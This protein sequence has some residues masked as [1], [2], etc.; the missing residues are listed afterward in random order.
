M[1]FSSDS[2]HSKKF[3]ADWDEANITHPTALYP[4]VGV[5]NKSLIIHS[6]LFIKILSEYSY[7]NSYYRWSSPN[8]AH[9]PQLILTW[10]LTLP[11]MHVNWCIFYFTVKNHSIILQVM[12]LHSSLQLFP[13][14][15]VISSPSG[16][17]LWTWVESPS[18]EWVG[19]VS[20]LS[21]IV[22]QVPLVLVVLAVLSQLLL[23]L[24]LEQVLLPSH[25]H[26]VALQSLHWMVHWLSVLDLALTELLKTQLERIQSEW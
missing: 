19:A 17:L 18:G 7:I 9:M 22:Q 24:G 12:L 1:T 20:A 23:G 25:Q 10:P 8:P 13:P 16:V 6:T 14:V 15:L 5:F 21:Y 26:W 3:L 4:E 11:C 2:D